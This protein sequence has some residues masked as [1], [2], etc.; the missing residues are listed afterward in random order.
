MAKPRRAF[1]P[2]FESEAVEL[3]T[4]QGSGFVE[5]D[6]ELDLGESILRGRKRAL[7]AR[8]GR[9]FPGKGIPLAREEEPRRLQAEVKRLTIRRDTL[10]E[11]R[12]SLFE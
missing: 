7:D 1:T 4:D 8:G 3:F 2:E 9:A 11:A 6:R 10:K 12:A 5:A